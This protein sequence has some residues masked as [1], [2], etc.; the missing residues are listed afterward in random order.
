MRLTG[1]AQTVISQ[2]CEVA[3]GSGQDRVEAAHI[4][5]ALLRQEEDIASLMLQSSDVTAEALGAQVSRLARAGEPSISG[6]LPRSASV[7]RA[8]ELAQRIARSFGQDEIGTEHMLLAL[9]RDPGPARR[10]LADLGADPDRLGAELT[11]LLSV[12]RSRLDPPRT[13]EDDRP[14]VLGAPR[15]WMVP[16]RG[17]G[18]AE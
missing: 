16:T 12:P 1:L 9:T 2:A 13:S 18:T 8:L 7:T 10:V 3:R 15:A 17:P 4:L 14:E 11:R 5:L 6:P